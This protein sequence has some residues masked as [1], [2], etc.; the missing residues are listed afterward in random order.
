[1]IR[2]GSPSEGIGRGVTHVS[3]VHGGFAKVGVEKGPRPPRKNAG[4]GKVSGFVK[5]DGRSADAKERSQN[6][7]RI[8]QNNGGE[9]AKK[10]R[11]KIFW[12]G[13]EDRSAK[14]MKIRKNTSDFLVS[15][16]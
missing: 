2:D 12:R 15:T 9:E 4:G 3:C 10:S 14:S 5:S 1:L 11:G 6:G 13:I 8:K 16:H 7:G